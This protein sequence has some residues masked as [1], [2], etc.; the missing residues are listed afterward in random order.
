MNIDKESNT[1]LYIFYGWEKI[2]WS[3]FQSH[4]F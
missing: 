4:N 2:L 1:V 3:F